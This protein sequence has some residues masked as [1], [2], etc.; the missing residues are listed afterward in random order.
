VPEDF[1]TVSEGAF[2]EPRLC[3]VLGRWGRREA[4]VECPRPSLVAP[5]LFV[6]ARGARVGKGLA[7]H[8]N[9]LPPIAGRVQGEL[10]NPIGSGVARLAV[11]FEGAERIVAIASGAYHKLPDA[12]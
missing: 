9:E 3:G 2:C 4:E 8:R 6:A 11:G 5:L 7:C 1:Q 10:E 12:P